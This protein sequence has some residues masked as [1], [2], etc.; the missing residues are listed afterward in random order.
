MRFSAG[1]RCTTFILLILFVSV[2]FAEPAYSKSKQHESTDKDKSKEEPTVIDNASSQAQPEAKSSSFS[3][4]SDNPKLNINTEIKSDAAKTKELKSP[5]SVDSS[6]FSASSPTSQTAYSSK[7]SPG[8]ID[9]KPDDSDKKELP[10]DAK[11]VE[12]LNFSDDSVEFIKVIF[13][14]GDNNDEKDEGTDDSKVETKNDEVADSSKENK[15]SEEGMKLNKDLENHVKYMTNSILRSL[16]KNAQ[17]ADTEDQEPNEFEH[18]E[19]KPANSDLEAEEGLNEEQLAM[20][21]EFRKS[22]ENSDFDTLFRLADGGHSKSQDQI[23]NGYL[24]AKI[25]FNLDALV[26]RVIRYAAQGN[27]MA[28]MVRNLFEF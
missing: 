11:E 6:S 28:N 1:W 13:Q 3:I 2:T 10:T 26:Q 24:F 8:K 25:P 21:N 23:L 4:K 14:L 5:E 16:S 19:P 20:H 22:V 9:A 17:E 18:L 12:T 15:R 27:A 7:E